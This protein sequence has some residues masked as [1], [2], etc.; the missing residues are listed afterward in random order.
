MDEK[1][2][3]DLIME[4]N[5]NVKNKY[6]LFPLRKPTLL[7]ETNTN[8]QT[9]QL[10]NKGISKLDDSELVNDTLIDSQIYKNNNIADPIS[11][12]DNNNS[13]RS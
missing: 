4:G 1:N 12:K 2:A 9:N 11:I 10:V 8:I 6:E 7:S 13:I 5:L 3:S